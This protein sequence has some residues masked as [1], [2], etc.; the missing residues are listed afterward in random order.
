M[1]KVYVDYLPEL[2]IIPCC[3]HFSKQKKK[4][5]E[6]SVLI[7]LFQFP[8]ELL[9]FKVGKRENGKGVVKQ[10]RNVI[11]VTLWICVLVTI[12]YPKVRKFI[13]IGL[14]LYCSLLSK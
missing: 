4:K 2:N 14:A 7:V 6:G 3:W 12:M 11:L 5:K 8:A 13:C 1:K 9:S 10:E